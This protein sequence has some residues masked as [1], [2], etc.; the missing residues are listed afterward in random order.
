MTVKSF[1]TGRVLVGQK[2][3]VPAPS[4]VSKNQAIQV[5]VLD[6]RKAASDFKELSPSF[7]HFILATVGRLRLRNKDRNFFL[8][9]DNLMHLPTNSEVQLENRTNESSQMTVIRYER[10]V[11]PAEVEEKLSRLGMVSLDLNDANINQARA[12]RA[13]FQEMVFEQSAGQECWETI[14]Q[15]RLVELGV[16][17]L[18]LNHRRLRH[19]LPVLE[20][21]NESSERVA[22]YALQLKENF[23]QQ[24]TLAEAARVTGLSS[25]QF[26][27]LFRQVTGKNWCKYVMDLRLRHA[28]GLLVETNRSVLEVAFDC[29]FEDLSHFHRSFKTAHGCSPMTYREQRQVRIPEEKSAAAR[30]AD[31]T[32]SGFRFRG[33]KGW[34]WSTDQYLEEI[35][36][37]AELKMNFLMDCDGALTMT[38]PGTS[39]SEEWWQPMGETLREAYSKVIHSCQQQGLTFCFALHPKLAKRSPLESGDSVDRK[40]FLQHYL[41]IQ[42]QNVKWFGICLDGT[43]WGPAGPVATGVSHAA[44]VNEVYQMLLDNDDEAQFLFRPVA[45][46][47]D[48][49]NPEQHAYLEA[50]ARDMHPDVFAFWDGDGVVTPRITTVAAESFKGV[51]KHRL[52]LCD[53]YPVNDASPTMHL[54]P[55][56]GRDSDLCEAVDGYLSNPMH[57]QSQINRIPLATC[58]DYAFNPAGY[59]PHRSIGQAIIRFAKTTEQQRVLKELV[60]AY[61]GFIVAGGGTGTNPVRKKFGDLQA[62]KGSGAA[63]AEMIQRF[64]GLLA[65]LTR[66]FAREFLDAR[67]TVQ[68][69]INW[70]K[71]RQR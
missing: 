62:E 14:L 66:H 44:F 33:T 4:S 16:R 61:P 38:K 59:N 55:L 58:A 35:P 8:N 30:D 2:L 47:G 41:W 49:T 27:R 28:T 51:V 45:C 10:D 71:K 42:Q 54:G 48:G 32:S 37:L 69:D 13:L 25:R 11:L 70:M 23:T 65:R 34:Y 6:S 52:F 31:A 12:I 1:E 3:T 17:V 43:S 5:F 21:G 19:N 29:G 67:K 64:D 39:L 46:S 7:S 26:T 40:L 50:L 60:D 9:S 36:K 18:R 20:P 15:S 57:P 63:T 68:D 56:S 22:R 53:N 24:E